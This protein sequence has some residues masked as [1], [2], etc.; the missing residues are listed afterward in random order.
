MEF[1]ELHQYLLYNNVILIH[2][3]KLLYQSKKSSYQ[4]LNVQK[5]KLIA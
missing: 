1:I 4:K 3:L 2:D 5:S